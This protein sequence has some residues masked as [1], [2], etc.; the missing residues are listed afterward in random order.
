MK[1]LSRLFGFGILFVITA[2]ASAGYKL[3]IGVGHNTGDNIS[4]LVDFIFFVSLGIAVILLW[5]GEEAT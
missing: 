4:M 2:M 3:L 1:L 5:L